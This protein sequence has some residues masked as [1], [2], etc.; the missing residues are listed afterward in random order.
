MSES[1]EAA[2]GQFEQVILGQMLRTAGIA[3]HEPI[4]ADDDE[5]DDDSSDVASSDDAFSQLVTQ[6]LAGAIERA[7]GLGLKSSL[8]AALEGRKP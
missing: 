7:G 8:A 1:L 6:S 3:R 4:A 2:C 5:H